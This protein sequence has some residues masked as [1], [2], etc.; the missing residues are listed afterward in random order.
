MKLV[1]YD[2]SES[3]LRL[4][5]RNQVQDKNVKPADMPS[6]GRVLAK[7]NQIAKS[8]GSAFI[9]CFSLF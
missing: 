4:P 7:V 2:A 8:L 6:S 3:S 1:C 5:E 9:G